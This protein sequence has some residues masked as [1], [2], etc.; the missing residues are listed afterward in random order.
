MNKLIR[1]IIIFLFVC[2][3]LN[4]NQLEDRQHLILSIHENLINDFLKHA[5]K[6][7]GSGGN[8][9]ASYHWLLIDPHVEI[10]AEAIYFI[11]EILISVGDIKTK[12]DIQG[13]VSSSFDMESNKI[14]LKIE[15]AK[16]IIDV[17][18]FG[19][20]YIITELDVAKYFP[21]PFILNGPNVFDDEVDFQL[22][23]GE[24]RI[25]NVS[26]N[27]SYLTLSKDAIQVYS[28]LNFNQSKSNE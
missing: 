14:R 28:V 27:D 15:E 16:V 18:L 23:N 19:S 20:N 6:V 25:V 9:I 26:I 8:S 5:G 1:N 12:K 4:A 22:P 11:S 24:T 2:Y 10:E 13:Y 3:Y 21:K 17:N 7:E